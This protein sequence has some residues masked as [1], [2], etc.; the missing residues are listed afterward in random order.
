MRVGKKIQSM[1]AMM[2]LITSLYPLQTVIAADQPSAAGARPVTTQEPADP[3][4]SRPYFSV[5]VIRQGQLKDQGIS[6]GAKTMK[7]AR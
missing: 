4:V 3:T 2:V 7:F 1:L 6:P 5:V